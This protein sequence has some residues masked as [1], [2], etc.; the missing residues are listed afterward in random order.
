MVDIASSLAP[1]VAV[2]DPA[3]TVVATNG[4]LDGRAPVPPLGVLATA[5]KKGSDTVT[6][7]PRAGVRI[8]LVVLRWH[9]GTVLAGR[10]LR[11]VEAIESAIEGI[12]M[13]A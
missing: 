2:Y 8:G 1:F 12:V 13:V 3:G 5:T 6:W 9:G 7:Q 11:R 4:R 10:S